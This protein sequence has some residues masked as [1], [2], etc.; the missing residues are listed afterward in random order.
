MRNRRPGGRAL[1]ESYIE[2]V[3]C[4]FIKSLIIRDD[5]L[6][7]GV[8]RRY[9]KKRFQ[10]NSRCRGFVAVRTRFQPPFGACISSC[11]SETNFFVQEPRVAL[12]LR[13]SKTGGLTVPYQYVELRICGEA[14]V[15]LASVVFRQQSRRA[16]TDHA[17]DVTTL[18]RI[19]HTPQARGIHASFGCGQMPATWL[20][21]LPSLPI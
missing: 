11:C 21:Y 12:V 6:P 13:G 16:H 7:L 19:M 9:S 8:N 1:R 2:L 14:S 20:R 3:R 5:P 4:A 17:A 18:M 10:Q 15:F